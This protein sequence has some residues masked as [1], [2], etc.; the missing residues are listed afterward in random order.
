MPID[1][2][3]TLV[4]REG[5]AGAATHEETKSIELIPRR[6]RDFIKATCNFTKGSPSE[7]RVDVEL[8]DD[9]LA[10]DAEPVRVQW[11]PPD[12]DL[13]RG[14]KRKGQIALTRQAPRGQLFAEVTPEVG[15]VMRVELSVDDYPR[16]LIFDVPCDNT[17]HVVERNRS[18][19]Q[20]RIARPRPTH[21]DGVVAYRWSDLNEADLEDVVEVQLDVPDDRFKPRP[22]GAVRDRLV[23]GI[24]E[25]LTET[26][27]SARSPGAAGAGFYRRSA[28]GIRGRAGGGW[29]PSSAAQD[30]RH[31]GKVEAI[32][33]G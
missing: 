26:H 6:P 29:H 28:G 5:E 27:Q 22:E 14:A 9:T 23:V 21:A 33:A 20:V 30:R 24:V 32:A 12:E 16:A 19:K 25:D 17:S 13:P 11:N 1:S 7:I 4:L 2:R 31:P 15:K 3:L 18:P 10:A 8:L